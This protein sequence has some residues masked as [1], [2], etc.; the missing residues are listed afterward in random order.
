MVGRILKAHPLFYT[1]WLFLSLFSIWMIRNTENVDFL[2]I[3]VFSIS[4]LITL[5]KL[6]IYTVISFEFTSQSIIVRKGVF[7][8]SHDEIHFFRIKD[9]Q[10]RKPFWYRF[11]G[12]SKILVYT[13][14]TY[15]NVVE[16]RGM[17]FGEEI[18]N[19]LI[20]Q[21]MLKRGEFGV[22]EYDVR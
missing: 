21:A 3:L 4:I 6:I 16:M 15:H 13:S 14:D 12:M 18:R 19:F 20:N 22:K 8:R 11:F 1:N 7:N 17:S 5:V 2:F 10:L 9:V